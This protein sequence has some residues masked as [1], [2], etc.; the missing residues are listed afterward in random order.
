MNFNNKQIEEKFRSLPETLQNLIV[1]VRTA[2]II[3]EIGQSHKL[4]IDQI[5]KLADEIG[6]VMMG[7]TRPNDFMYNIGKKLS[8]SP[9]LAKEITKEVDEKIFR[10]IREELQ[11]M[12]GFD[13]GV[14]QEKKEVA[15]VESAP[16]KEE[17]EEKPRNIFQ[18]KMSGFFKNE[19]SEEKTQ[20]QNEKSPPRHDPYRETVE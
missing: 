5:G 18:E 11:K 17:L 12:R 4:H 6:F 8:L 14:N 9:D 19:K 15:S 16:P 1:S 2:E 10:Q 13:G 7:L 3:R 20:P